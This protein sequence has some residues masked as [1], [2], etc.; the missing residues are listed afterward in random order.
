MKPKLSSG[1]R[2]T[3]TQIAWLFVAS[4]VDAIVTFLACLLLP[5]LVVACAV[6]FVGIIVLYALSKR[7]WM[8]NLI[9]R[10]VVPGTRI[11]TLVG[12]DAKMLSDKA[13]IPVKP[14]RLILFD[15]RH[16]TYICG[17]THKIYAYSYMG[18]KEQ[19]ILIVLLLL[20]FLLLTVL[21]SL[22]LLYFVI[23]GIQR[24]N[25]DVASFW[26]LI[27]TPFVCISLGIPILIYYGI[28]ASLWGATRLRK[29]RRYGHIVDGTLLAY[30]EQHKKTGSEYT[31][32]FQFWTPDAELAVSLISLWQYPKGLVGVI[33]QPGDQLKIL[34][35]NVRCFKIL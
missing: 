27:V 14:K 8:E 5:A 35:V 23:Y 15:L 34:Y 7:P 22:G 11:L 16:E 33:P 3:R 17:Q 29:L 21:S 24:P 30:Q 28:L 1:F 31:L 6:F 10:S 26:G 12:P 9:Q 20:P 13:I 25:P 2:L 18:E 4:V 32:Q 19:G